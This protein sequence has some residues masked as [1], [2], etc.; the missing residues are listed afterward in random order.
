MRDGTVSQ[1]NN[2][3]FSGKMLSQAPL[4]STQGHLIYGSRSGIWASLDPACFVGGRTT[5]N[6]VLNSYLQQNWHVEAP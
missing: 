6:G 2:D 5:A 4:Y 3:F 1:S